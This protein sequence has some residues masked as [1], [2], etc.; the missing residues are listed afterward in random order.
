[1]DSQSKHNEQEIIKSREFPPE[2]KKSDK[3]RRQTDDIFK[4]LF[5]SMMEMVAIHELIFD[6]TGIP[7]DYIILDCN[8]A[9]TKITGLTREISCGT[10]ASKLY[11]T[12]NPPY[13]SLYA[14]AAVS[15]KTIKFESFF[16]P[17]NKYFSVTAVNI[18][19]NKFATITED[20]T[21]KKNAETELVSSERRFRE[22]VENINDAFFIHDFSG[23]ILDCNDNAVK[24][25]GYSRKELLKMFLYQIDNPENAG[26][27]PERMKILSEEYALVF[28]SVHR[29]KYGSTIPVNISAKVVSRED[30]GVIHSFFRDITYK[31]KEEEERRIFEIHA[32]KVKKIESLG[33][34]AGGIA[35]DFNNL[36][37][38]LFGYIENARTHAGDKAKVDTNLVK[39][40]A[41]FDRAK[42]LTN[43]LLTFSKAGLPRTN[44]IDVRTMLQKTVKFMTSGTSINVVFDFAKELRNCDLDE[45]QIIQA[46][47]NLVLNARQAMS[48]GGTLR[49][50]ALNTNKKAGAPSVLEDGKEYVEIVISDTGPGIPADKLP[51][52]FDP[53]FSAKKHGSGLGLSTAFS[54]IKRHKGFIEVESDNKKGTSMHIYLPATDRV[55]QK[56]GEI[57]RIKIAGTGKILILDD[58]LFILELLKGILNELGYKVDTFEKA[59]D[60]LGVFEKSV[61]T[62]ARYDIVILDLTIPGGLGGKEVVKRFK[63]L[64]PAVLAVASSGY[65][66]NEIMVRPKDFGFD[67]SLAKPYSLE[68]LLKTLQEVNSR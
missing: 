63:E 51:N 60:A 16:E 57:T 23:R 65:S 58:E 61:S 39:A 68:D 44:T 12:G 64:D 59:E 53:Y 50:A 40:I 2:I 29:K 46:I 18:G 31:I 67:A 45:N 32:Q 26:I 5:N 38:G 6:E 34:L 48:G 24:L 15:G 55:V 47:D 10:T 4:V 9:F 27:I 19:K 56:P 66:D 8:P 33:I 14:E 35:H 43:Q 17:M 7:S 49:V 13:L 41:V 11:K 21:E 37:T 1:M 20:I 54:I 42:E 52:I 3:E 22:I 28:D 25:L 36:L 30:C 62:N